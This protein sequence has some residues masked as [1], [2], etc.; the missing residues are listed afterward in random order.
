MDDRHIVELYWQRDEQAIAETAAKYEDYCMKISQ[1]ILSDRADSEE[2]VN[3][4]Y[5]HAWN[6]IPPERP[7]RLGAYLGRLARNLALNR[8]KA[9]TAQKRQGD[10]FAQSLDE[11]ADFAVEGL[12]PTDEVAARELG[13]QISA[14]LRT[15]SAETRAIFVQ[16]Y[17]HCN[18]IEALARRFGASESRIKTTLLRTRQRLKQHLAKEGYYEA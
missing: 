3:D 17:F 9:K 13:A 14:F 10:S 5:L 2:N 18:S 1:N 6:A 12:D 11:L 15:Q 8:Y 7:E 16:R 4:T